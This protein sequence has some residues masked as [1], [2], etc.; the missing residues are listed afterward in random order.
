MSAISVL[1][2]VYNEP[3]D[4]IQ[5]AIDSILTQTFTDFEFI[6]INDKP[7]RLELKELLEC[8]AAKDSRIRIH[9]NPENIG[10]TKSLNVGLKLCTGKY[11]ARM[12]ADDVS[13]PE[14]FAKQVAMMDSNPEIGVCGTYIKTFGEKEHIITYPER[15]EQ[16]FIFFDSPF[17]HPVVMMRREVLDTNDIS[18]DSQFKYA[19][20]FDLWERLYSITQFAN[21]PEILLY[22][23]ISGN[24]VTSAKAKDQYAFS[25]AIKGRAI[26]RYCIVHNI[27]FK[28]TP[29]VDLKQIKAYRKEVSDRVAFDNKRLL[30]YLYR[31]IKK[32]RLQTLIFLVRS[33]D[34]FR[35]KFLDGLKTFYTLAF[36]PKKAPFLS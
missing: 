23:R 7:D 9:I 35:F 20:D 21:I 36:L 13:L 2:S 18:Y 11:I 25:T 29:P 26:N 22:Y 28:I 27:N 31:S 5:L 4:W 3:L 34:V 15:H 30:S 24:Q 33:G 17:A 10:L 12:D 32:H 6:I 8:N 19:Q 14:R 1:M 16:C